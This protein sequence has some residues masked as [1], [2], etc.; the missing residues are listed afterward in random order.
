MTF[1][2]DE[3]HS[4]KPLTELMQQWSSCNSGRITSKCAISFGRGWKFHRPH[5]CSMSRELNNRWTHVD[6]YD[7]HT[8]RQLF[9]AKCNRL[10]PSARSEASGPRTGA[11]SVING[12][13]SVPAT[14]PA[15]MRSCFHCTPPSVPATR[16]SP[17]HLADVLDAELM[18]EE[19]GPRTN[20]SHIGSP[21]SDLVIVERQVA[22][23]QFG[24]D[25]SPFSCEVSTIAWLSHLAATR[26]Y[27]PFRLCPASI[28]MNNSA[29][30]RYQRT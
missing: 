4:T 9:L 11:D 18:H 5:L 2:F 14:K 17:G 20:E 15:A 30:C 29:P 3:N 6:G 22:A 23:M 19:L 26:I 27:I 7:G 10:A 16:P 24:S 12:I 8:F 25:L 13:G 21:P 28:P 1:H